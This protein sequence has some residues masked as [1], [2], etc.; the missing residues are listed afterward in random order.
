MFGTEDIRVQLAG[1]KVPD[2]R[3]WSLP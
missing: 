3:Y 1:P 2:A